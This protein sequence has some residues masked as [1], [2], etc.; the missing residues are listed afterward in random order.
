ME[1]KEQNAEESRR[2][3]AYSLPLFGDG[4]GKDRAA[5][6][7]LADAGQEFAEG[8]RASIST[9]EM[10]AGESRKAGEGGLLRE[11]MKTDADEA[12]KFMATSPEM[13]AWRA[14]AT[15]SSYEKGGMAA[16]LAKW[17]KKY[18]SRKCLVF[19]AESGGE[20]GL[21]AS[22]AL[23]ETGEERRGVE[24]AISTLG[25]AW[26]EGR[27]DGPSASMRGALEA[28]TE[29]ALGCSDETARAWADAAT[30]GEEWVRGVVR[31]L[32]KKLMEKG[33]GE[34]RRRAYLTAARKGWFEGGGE[35]LGNM[36]RA[37]EED[38]I[39]SQVEWTDDKVCPFWITAARGVSFWREVF[40][41]LREGGAAPQQPYFPK[42][43][44]RKRGGRHPALLAWRLADG[45]VKAGRVVG[46][47]GEL[48]RAWRGLALYGSLFAGEASDDALAKAEKA[49]SA[50]ERG[51]LPEP[52]EKPNAETLT[53]GRITKKE[54]LSPAGWRA[55]VWGG[56]FNAALDG[57]R[58]AM[59][60]SAALG[61]SSETA[62][63]Q[64]KS[65]S[66]TP[67]TLKFLGVEAER[68]ALEK[69]AEKGGGRLRSSRL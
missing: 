55:G 62:R 50:M 9:A 42:L 24:T 6:K 8:K 32:T 35:I 19:L 38:G 60:A 10:L 4:S 25:K 28:M 49:L 52:W 26:E 14:L 37:G 21:W 11:T 46:D 48:I 33:M 23:V 13:A 22:A 57:M 16:S 68:E 7:A 5:L 34:T 15:K 63:L 59:E 29:A 17:G 51:E 1:K 54:P 41:A 40:D 65:L 44:S 36:A 20:A 12:L 67:E 45:S 2:T 66:A 18:G 47:A 53:R 69:T 30:V 56:G 61:F 64:A 3:S 27:A 43:A 31:D 58:N 39:L